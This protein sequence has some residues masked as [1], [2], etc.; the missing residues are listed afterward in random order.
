MKN[1]RSYII[2]FF[3][4][5]LLLAVVQVSY[6]ESAEVV[7]VVSAEELSQ[8]FEQ[9]KES[10]VA[11]GADIVYDGETIN[12]GSIGHSLD[13]N[14]HTISYAPAH[15]K[16]LFSVSHG[17]FTIRDSAGGGAIAGFFTDTGGHLIDNRG[18]FILESGM[19]QL[20]GQGDAIYNYSG[21]I[22][23]KGGAVQANADAL[24]G[25]AGV[26]NEVGTLTQSGGIVE[27]KGTGSAVV[28][29]GQFFMN[30]GSIVSN[31][32]TSTGVMNFS[33]K[34]YSVIGPDDSETPISVPG[35]VFTLNRGEIQTYGENSHAI[36][37]YT[38]TERL[39]LRSGTLKSNDTYVIARLTPD[40]EKEMTVHEAGQYRTSDGGTPVSITAATKKL[41]L[42][43]ETGM[44]T[45]VPTTSTIFIDGEPVA[46]SAYNINGNNYFKLRELSFY[47]WFGAKPFGVS[48]DELFQCV[49]ISSDGFYGE[50][51]PGE[52]APDRES[53][54]AYIT[55]Q[56][57]FVD[58]EEVFFTVYN[59]DGSNYFKLR[60]LGEALDFGIEWDAQSNAIRINT[61]QPYGGAE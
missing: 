53:R 27:V 59:I 36:C 8:A 20:S 16:E 42:Q 6:G 14:G 22:S 58:D 55:K 30:G 11:L 15:A 9:Q 23:I 35:A 28:N 24:A 40:Y 48:Y 44:Q 38:D 4:V 19:V 43:G 29:C 39:V 34:G 57:V 54:C 25:I 51:A 32:T 47:M 17:T 33:P 7:V 12:V 50:D 18:D 46:F 1:Y 56:R 37:Y 13:L 10:H 60:D 49:I 21:T 2:V 41:V 52:P 5:F 26:Y 31:G 61:K 3:L 45:A